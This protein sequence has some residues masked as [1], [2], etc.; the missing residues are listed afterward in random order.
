MVNITRYARTAW[1]AV[2][3]PSTGRWTAAAFL[4][5]ASMVSPLTPPPA[6]AGQQWQVAAGASSR[7][8]GIQALG[9]YPG[10]IWVNAGDSVTW[11]FRSG[12]EHT[13]TF[14]TIPPRTPTG[15][16]GPAFLYAPATPNNSVYHGTEYVN[17]GNIA[18][19]G[20][21]FTVN[22]AT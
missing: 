14:G 10:D 6:Q 2:R 12:E 16:P 1:R 18:R 5:L 11:N 9:F 20:G 21:A 19:G 7:S 4:G 17:S 22:F 8:E 15:A 13:V 3:R